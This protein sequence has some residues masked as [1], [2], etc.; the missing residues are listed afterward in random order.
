MIKMR[1]PQKNKNN[2]GFTLIELLGV[3]SIIALLSSILLYAVNSARGKTSKSK[4][5][6]DINQIAKGLGI[7]YNSCNSYPAFAPATTG[8]KLEATKGLFTGTA[9]ACNA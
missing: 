3:I 2:Y 6:A 5:L 4:R 1:C 8:L 7:V 9:S